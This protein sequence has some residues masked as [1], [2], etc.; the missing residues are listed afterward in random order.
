MHVH[1][2]VASQQTAGANLT[3]LTS[4][5]MDNS[6]FYVTYNVLAPV[7]C[8][9]EQPLFLFLI[10]I[11]QITFTLAGHCGPSLLTRFSNAS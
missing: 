8:L 2:P 3:Q 4:G 6:V 1:P 10:S 11:V 5:T 9:A 7:H